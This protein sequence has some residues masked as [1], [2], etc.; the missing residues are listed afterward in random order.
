[1][2]EV[3]IGLATMACCISCAHY[4][5]SSSLN[6]A[7]SHRYIHA[8]NS[9]TNSAT[10]LPKRF[11]DR[12]SRLSGRKIDWS[13]EAV[14]LFCAGSQSKSI[15]SRHVFLPFFTPTFDVA[16][17]YKYIIERDF[18]LDLDH[19]L[20]LV[21]LPCNDKINFTGWCALPIRL[22]AAIISTLHA[23]SR[24]TRTHRT[25]AHVIYFQNNKL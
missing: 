12:W 7:L 5:P 3:D 1:M 14:S 20:Q 17:T 13:S 11:S 25:Q 6:G 2:L 15:K 22:F 8:C 10:F 24:M 21:A 19:F 4:F 18:V 23:K 16:L 9:N